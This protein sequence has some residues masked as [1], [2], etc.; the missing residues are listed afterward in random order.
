[1]PSGAELRPV[2][3]N[4]WEATGFLLD[5]A[6]QMALAERAAALGCELFVMDDGWFGARVSDNAGLGDWT[7]NPERF[8]H[9]LA[10]LIARVTERRYGE[11]YVP[12]RLPFLPP[13]ARWQDADTG[14][15]FMSA[16]LTTHGLDAGLFR[17]HDS[18]VTHLR[19]LP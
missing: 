5:E 8:P 13:S 16:F 17:N 10:P 18:A 7:P 2:L 15:T 1:M 3:Y 11:P 19:R 6:N 4:S 12:A 9:G 14:M